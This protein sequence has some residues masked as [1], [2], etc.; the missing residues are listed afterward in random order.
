[1][2][3]RHRFRG[4]FWLLCGLEVM[5]VVAT[6]SLDPALAA[7][8]VLAAIGMAG[9]AWLRGRRTMGQVARIFDD[10]AARMNLIPCDRARRV[11]AP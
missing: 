9:W 7:I 3:Y 6:A 10:A 8:P 2:R 11:T 5:V 4:L 1:M